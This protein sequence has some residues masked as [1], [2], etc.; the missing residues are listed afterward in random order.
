MESRCHDAFPRGDLRVEKG[1]NEALI[2]RSND[3]QKRIARR[4]ECSPRLPRARGCLETGALLVAT[5]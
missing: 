5:R 1:S 4:S 2:R 3:A